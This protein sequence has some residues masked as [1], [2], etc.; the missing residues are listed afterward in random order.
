MNSVVSDIGRTHRGWARYGRK[1]LKF[2][3]RMVK[4]YM[5]CT[6]KGA[7]VFA[8]VLNT[9]NETQLDTKNSTK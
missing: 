2:N 4:R 6:V 9:A 5:Y 1:L 8:E 3:P 7:I